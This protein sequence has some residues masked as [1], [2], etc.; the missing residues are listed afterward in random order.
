MKAIKQFLKHNSATIMTCFGAVGVVATAVTAVRATPKAMALIEQAGYEKASE[1]IPLFDMEYTPLTVTETIKVAWKPYIPSVA[2]GAATIACIFGANILNQR[3][4]AALASAYILLEQSYKE[5][6]DKVK[7]ELGADTESKI[8]ASIVKDKLSDSDIPLLGGENLMF[9][10]EHH[11]QIFERTMLEVRDAEYHLNRK[12]AMNGEVSLNEF[13]EL[14]D[15]P[16]VEG[17]DAIGWS[18][19]DGFDFYNYTWIEFEHELVTLDDGMECYIL[20][21]AIA[22]S[23]LVPF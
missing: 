17:G 11:G 10:E 8:R 16:G 1:S 2:I 15:L 23:I 19:E 3:Q 14:L 21:T 22:P 5:Y 9:Y 12:L 13:L 6:K 20:N 18:Q 4:Q 7:A